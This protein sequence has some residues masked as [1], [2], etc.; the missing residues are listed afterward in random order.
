MKTLT[1]EFWL[2]IPEHEICSPP[3]DNSKI[4]KKEEQIQVFK[5]C[6]ESF[7]FNELP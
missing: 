4:S 1:E 7:T 3:V 5:E 6:Y 2:E